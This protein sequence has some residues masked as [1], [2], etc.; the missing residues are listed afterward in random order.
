MAK[1]IERQ[2]TE[3]IA[4]PANAACSSQKRPV[5]PRPNVPPFPTFGEKYFDITLESGPVSQDGRVKSNHPINL[6][7]N[8]VPQVD[9]QL[10]PPEKDRG[11]QYPYDILSSSSSSVATSIQAVTSHF[12]GMA[13]TA[14]P[15]LLGYSDCII[16]G[17]PV[18][19]IQEETVNGYLDK[20]VMVGETLAETQARRRAF[21]DGMNAGTFFSCQGECRRLPP[22]MG[23]GIQLDTIMTLSLVLSH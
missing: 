3:P 2:L 10:S 8:L 17:K 11:P 7:R 1:C 5:T 21:L 6:C 13:L 20:T 23:T 4:I 22:A 15:S 18:P 19:Q 9:T 14:S 16:C 12:D